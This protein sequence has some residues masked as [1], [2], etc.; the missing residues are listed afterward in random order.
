MQILLK[1]RLFIIIAFIITQISVTKAY[2]Q[3][4]HLEPKVVSDS[5][6]NDFLRLFIASSMKNV[7]MLVEFVTQMLKDAMGSNERFLPAPISM[8]EIIIKTQC[9]HLK[10]QI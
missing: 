4:T 2:G 10:H 5:S 3:V 1:M 6:I 7:Q 8:N 9:H